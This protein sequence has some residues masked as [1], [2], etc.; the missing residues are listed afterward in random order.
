[1]LCATD[2]EC[3]ILPRSPKNQLHEALENELFEGASRLIA[4]YSETDLVECFEC[5]EGSFKSCLHIIAGMSNTEQATKLCRELMKRIRNSKNKQC[6][7]DM[8]T[9]DE[10]DVIRWK[11]RA[12]VASIH[13]AA[14]N[15]N[16]GVVRLL[17]QE[18]G[19][20]VN[21]STSE[22]LEDEPKKGITALEW[23]A[24]KGHAEVVKVLL[25]NKADVNV[26]RTD[27]VTPL[28]IAAQE[29]HLEVVKLLL[30]NKADV[31][32]N[33]HTDGVTPLLM[34]A[35]EGHTDV[36]KLLLDNKADVNASQHN[37]VTP[38]YTAACAGHTDVVKLLLDNKADVNASKRCGATPLYIA[39]C[40][41]HIEVVK[42]LLAN[43]A[44]V[45]A[46]HGG[47]FGDKPIDAA[48]RNHHSE[49]VKL[50]Q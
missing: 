41:G 34:P 47:R 28:W 11:A 6:L 44:N 50:L 8:T 2:E 26:S 30:H 25:D 3:N 48:R 20:D 40:K 49:I 46:R 21:Y 23:A 5:P 27:G 12:R 17:C 33:R 22:T 1:V 43:K 24:R 39:A 32:A 19:V 16:S 38:L 29:G 36:V 15:G 35:Q 42:L 4:S 37:G 18:Y 14:Y 10:F 9:V 7:L 31:N 45:N 13:I